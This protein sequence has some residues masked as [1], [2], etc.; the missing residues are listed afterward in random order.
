MSSKNFAM[1]KQPKER[2]ER[3][4]PMRYF[5]GILDIAAVNSFVIYK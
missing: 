3:R 5:Y 2:A 1:I 4:W